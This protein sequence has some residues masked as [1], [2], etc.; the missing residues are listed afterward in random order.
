MFEPMATH[1]KAVLSKEEQ[2]KKYWIKPKKRCIHASGKG[3]I[4]TVMHIRQASYR[5]R[6]GGAK[7]IVGGVVCR[8]IGEDGQE[9]RGEFHT[10][11]LKE[12]I[13]KNG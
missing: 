11:E 10:R 7:V 3:P 9:E 8:W 13:E 6:D 4:M 2:R 5:K 1:P 12:Y